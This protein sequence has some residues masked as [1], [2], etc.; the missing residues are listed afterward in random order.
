[1]V[2]NLT[3]HEID[4]FALEYLACGNQ[5]EAYK[6][7]FEQF[8]WFDKSKITQHSNRIMKNEVIR[9]RMAMLSKQATRS[10]LLDAKTVLLR[11]A[12]IAFADATEIVRV[13]RVNCRY[14]WGTNHG[15]QATQAEYDA[16]CVR[17][18]EEA[19][20][21]G[22]EYIDPDLPKGGLGFMAKRA[23]HPDCPECGGE[24]YAETFIE[25]FANL[26]EDAK[27]LISSVEQTKYGIKVHMHNQVD[28]I[29]TLANAL[30]LTQPDIAL[31]VVNAIIGANT[32]S[33][34]VEIDITDESKAL[35]AYQEMTANAANRLG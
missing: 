7:A 33:K 31:Q 23:P 10:K 11:V 21:E 24:G 17:K 9:A 13:R 16:A 2:E 8:S 12:M 5:R 14:C 19:K 6:K 18:F 22:V 30:G 26:S 28:A 15:Y 25:D 1:M 4:L 27:A 29:K 20:R 32:D 34:H 3:N 35:D